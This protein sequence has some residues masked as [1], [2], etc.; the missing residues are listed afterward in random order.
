MAR[1]YNPFANVERSK[2]ETPW[3]DFTVA[4][5]NKERLALIDALQKEA[6]SLEADDLV[7]TIA[8]G[9]RSAA[10]GVERGDE[11]L[12]KLTESWDAGD[13]TVAQVTGLADF[14]SSE[15]AGEVE[16]GNG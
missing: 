12:N 10:A 16:E 8:L 5:P 4:A 7:G 9:M 15:I 14:I 1:K 2:V 3:G 13:L 6:E 11:L